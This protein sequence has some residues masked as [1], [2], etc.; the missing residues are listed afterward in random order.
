MA[1]W[2]NRT[3][4]SGGSRYGK[5][6]RVQQFTVQMAGLKMDCWTLARQYALVG[7]ETE[8]LPLLFDPRV[9]IEVALAALPVAADAQ[10]LARQITLVQDKAANIAHR[11]GLAAGPHP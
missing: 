4:H 5:K 8:T 7:W 6:P 11:P 10:M 3:P 1:Y 9:M 2:P